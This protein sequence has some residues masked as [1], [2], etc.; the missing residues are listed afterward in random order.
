MF[1]EMSLVVVVYHC[2]KYHL[3]EDECVLIR[4]MSH[5]RELW[6]T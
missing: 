2:F 3:E 4:N 1:I 6:A 5:L